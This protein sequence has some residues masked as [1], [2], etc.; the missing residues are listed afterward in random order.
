MDTNFF[1]YVKL[2]GASVAAGVANTA[3][4]DG[5][6]AKLT[7]PGDP[8]LGSS[9][10]AGPG[11]YGTHLESEQGGKLFKYGTYR[12]R[13]KAAACATSDE[14]VVTGVFTY[15]NDGTDLNAN[16]IN[17]NSE[18]DIEVLCAEP[19]VIYMTIWTDYTDDNHFQKTT[20]KINLVTGKY[21]QTTAGKEGEWGLGTKGTMS[22]TLPDLNFTTQFVEMGFTWKADSVRYF[23]VK[24]GVEYELWSFT[25]ASRKLIPQNPGAFMVNLWHN[26]S[27]WHNDL[28]ADYPTTEVNIEVDWFKYF[29]P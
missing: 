1:G 24:D 9:N 17:D 16:G 8:A 22:F 10:R 20:R 14:G 25:D 21:S 19:T 12:A 23:L 15:Q 5:K 18:L 26:S 11:S 29:E 13:V 2:S 3:A 6:T 28:P 27:H 7:F 4:S